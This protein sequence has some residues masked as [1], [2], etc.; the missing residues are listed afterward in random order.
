MRTFALTRRVLAV[1]AALATQPGCP[2]RNSEDDAYDLV[3]VQAVRD[4]GCADVSVKKMGQSDSAYEYQATGCSDVYSYGIDCEDT[5]TVVAGVRGPGL[6]G[7]FSV[8]A[9][10][11]G[12][13][14]GVAENLLDHAAAEVAA[15]PL[16]DA[17]FRAHEAELR[18]RNQK[19]RDE[20]DR[21]L[22]SRPTR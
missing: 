2:K 18:A 20:V 9:G 4:L 7:S 5:C 14:V 3:K 12:K 21:H 10:I 22:E 19:I 17:E 16:R 6:A 1:V 11:I 8:G 15:I 13:A